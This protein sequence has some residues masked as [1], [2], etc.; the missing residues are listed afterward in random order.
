MA[1][2]TGDRPN[3]VL[4][5]ADD[6]GYECLGSY[7]GESYS[8]PRLDALAATGVR[9]SHAYALPLCTPTRLQLMTGK[10]NFRN[11]QAFGIMD[12][13][14]T[15]F[16]HRLGAAGYRTCISGKWQLYSYNRR[17]TSRSGAARAC[18]PRGPAS[19]STAYVTPNTPRTKAPD[20]P[21][22]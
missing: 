13:N 17:S 4:I 16:A 1:H 10:Y 11:W 18:G 7:G 5:L 22:L 8:T 19:T 20:T 6:L 2:T 9:F 21:T 3:I 14:E 15:T 12:P